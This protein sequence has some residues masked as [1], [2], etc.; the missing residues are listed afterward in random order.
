MAAEAAT[1]ELVATEHME[2]PAAGSTATVETVAT[3][4]PEDSEDPEVREAATEPMEP[5]GQEAPRVLPVLD[6]ERLEAAVP[7]ALLVSAADGRTSAIQ[8]DRIALRRN[9]S[10][11]VPPA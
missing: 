2:D 6:R 11:S 9:F 5:A 3:A 1:A 8:H 10:V 4:V 7:Q